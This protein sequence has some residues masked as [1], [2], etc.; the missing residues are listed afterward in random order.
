MLRL[1]NSTHIKLKALKDDSKITM[2]IIFQIKG[3][4]LIE[5]VIVVVIISILAMVALPNLQHATERAYRAKCVSNLRTLG[6][7]LQ[8]Y[9]VDYNNFPPADGVAGDEP[10]PNRTE[11]G[12][13]PAANGSWDGVPWVLLKLRYVTDRNTF[14]CPVLKHRYPHKY[15]N[16]RYAYNSSAVDTG[17]HIGGANNIFYETDHIW[18]ARCLWVPYEASFKPEERI[19]YPHG[20]ENDKENVLFVDTTIELRNGREDFYATYTNPSPDH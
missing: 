13:G 20:E 15:Q 12:N 7:A 1:Y 18:L 16:F 3:F 6:V 19:E 5:L 17:G 10:S 11:V 4:T 14:Y 2:R 9:R 8:T